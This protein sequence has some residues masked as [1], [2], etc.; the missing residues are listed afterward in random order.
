LNLWDKKAKKTGTLLIYMAQQEFL[1]ELSGIITR[2]NEPMLLGG[3][4]SIIRFLLEKNKPGIHKHS[5][6]F[7]KVIN[8]YELIVLKMTGGIHLV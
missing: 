7:N 8:S 5:E 4:F 2:C 1:S 6:L 3:D